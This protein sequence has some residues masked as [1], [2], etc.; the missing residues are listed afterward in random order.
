M[1]SS[2][3]E[4]LMVLLVLV[5]NLFVHTKSTNPNNKDSYPNS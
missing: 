4:I 1:T 2:K 5:N 3:S